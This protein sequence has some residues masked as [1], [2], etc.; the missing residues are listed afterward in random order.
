[1]GSGKVQKLRNR[2]VD[3]RRSLHRRN[4]PGRHARPHPRPQLCTDRPRR[5]GPA[6]VA[7]RRRKPNPQRPRRNPLS[8][9]GRSALS[10]R[11]A[12]RNTTDNDLFHNSRSPSIP[13]S[14]AFPISSKAM[15]P[16]GW[17]LAFTAST[18]AFKT[19]RPNAKTSQ[20]SDFAH[21]L[22]PIY[23]QTLDLNAKVAASDLDPAIQ[24]QP[25]LR[26]RRKNRPSS[27]PR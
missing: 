9:L 21:K 24:S 19:Q 12:R 8:P 18:T 13:P 4:H 22:A 2:R 5:L 7:K 6:E 27:N 14:T 25:A 26:T 15:R 20:P 17:P 10:S 3:H 16:T 1:M 11:Q 23:R